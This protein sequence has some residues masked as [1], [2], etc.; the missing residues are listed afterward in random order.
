MTTARRA[1]SGD[2]VR[3]RRRRHATHV[4]IDDGERWA[5]LIGG[6]LLLVF[7]LSRGGRRGG[8]AAL[9]GG[10]LI[11]R[12]ARGHSRLY[13]ALRLEDGPMTHV[14]RAIPADRSHVLPLWTWGPRS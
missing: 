3:I 11:Y 13:T 7:G 6:S 4:N 8:L 14:A 1:G 5:S 12:A 10:A 2:A 9:S